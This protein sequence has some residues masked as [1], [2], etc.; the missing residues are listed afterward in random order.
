MYK[1]TCHCEFLGFAGLLLAINV[2]LAHVLA[3]VGDSGLWQW[4]QQILG[5]AGVLGVDFVAVLVYGVLAAHHILPRAEDVGPAS[6]CHI[7]VPGHIGTGLD[8]QDDF[9]YDND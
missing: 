5:G 3:S 7:G 2:D 9:F 1:P 6:Q 4:V 8:G